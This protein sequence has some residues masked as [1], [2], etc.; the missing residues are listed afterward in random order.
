MS[1]GLRGICCL[2]IGQMYLCLSYNPQIRIK[3]T[4]LFWHSLLLPTPAQENQTLA[5]AHHKYSITSRAAKEAKSHDSSQIDQQKTDH[6][7][8]LN[9]EFLP[10]P[11]VF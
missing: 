9:K 6:M 5:N 2:A 7:P 11:P 3:N 10:S 8:V 4:S 1:M